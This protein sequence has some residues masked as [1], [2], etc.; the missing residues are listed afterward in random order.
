MRKRRLSSQNITTI[1]VALLGAIGTIAVAYFA[2]RGNVA[3]I[4]LAIIATQTAES[5]LTASAILPT[6][7]ITNTLSISE[8]PTLPSI[9]STNTS[10]PANILFQDDFSTNNNGWRVGARN[11]EF[12]EQNLELV[13]GQYQFGAYFKEDTFTWINI[14]NLS[15]KN[16]YLS[17][18]TEVVQTAANSDLGIAIMFRY[19][20]HGQ[21]TYA[22]VFN[23]DSA[24]EFHVRNNGI[25]QR[26]YKGSSNAFQL[27][28]GSSNTF[29]LKFFGQ[30]FTAYANGQEIYTLEDSVLSGAGEIGLGAHGQ[31][32]KS[33]TIRFDNLLVTENLNP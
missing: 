6:L 21:S 10:F 3:P 4:E 16:F 29:G 22:I 17:V 8:M 9:N 2:F 20:N 32:G 15:A 23:N 24:F 14:P 31:G 18:E 7:S 26:L 25:W 1:V 27:Q 5:R 28:E 19:G 33:A 30:R 13:N 11:P 12:S